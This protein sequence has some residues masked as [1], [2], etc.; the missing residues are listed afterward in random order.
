[1]TSACSS[2]GGGLLATSPASLTASAPAPAP[3][4]GLTGGN[5]GNNSSGGGGGGGKVPPAIRE[6]LK[7]LDDQEW[8]SSLYSLLQSQTFNQ[9]RNTTRN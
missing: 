9:V 8:Q 7:S 1:M 5:S 4:T 2:V 3:S 6:F